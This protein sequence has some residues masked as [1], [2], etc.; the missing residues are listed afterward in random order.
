MKSYAINRFNIGDKVYYVT[1]D[2]DVDVGIRMCTVLFIDF[3][4]NCI[5]YTLSDGQRRSK[6]LY[7]TYEKA[8]EE[9]KKL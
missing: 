5:V 9:W 2:N 8:Y 3:Y 7:S 1:E 4:E 6:N